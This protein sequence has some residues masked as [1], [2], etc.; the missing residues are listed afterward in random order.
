[1]DFTDIIVPKDVD[2][3][4]ASATKCQESAKTVVWKVMK[5]VF[6]QL[7]VTINNVLTVTWQTTSTIVY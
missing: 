4:K 3:V 7:K 2:D 6:V 5:E 1:M